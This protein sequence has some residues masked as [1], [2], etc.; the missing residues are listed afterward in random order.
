MLSAKLQAIATKIQY[1]F[2][3]ASS[4][5]RAPNGIDAA[6]QRVCSATETGTPARKILESSLHAWVALVSEKDGVDV[7]NALSFE[8]VSLL[9]EAVEKL[10]LSGEFKANVNYTFYH[11]GRSGDRRRIQ[12]LANLLSMR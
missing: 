8:E 12:F 7:V 6:L 1:H 9:I 4:G 11:A 10:R 2:E 3:S 5:K